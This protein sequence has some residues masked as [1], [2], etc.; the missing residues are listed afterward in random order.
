M[1]VYSD[2]PNLAYNFL[3]RN[4]DL[5]KDKT[6]L[7][8]NIK[9]LH[10]TLFSAET[11]YTF[12]LDDLEYWNFLFLVKDALKSHFDLLVE[13]NSQSLQL[14][15]GIVC[16]AETGSGFHGFRKREWSAQQGNLHISLYFKPKNNF[17]NIHAGVLIASAVSILETIDSIPGLAGLASTKWVNDI[18]INNSKVSGIITQTSSIGN[19]ISGAMIGI[20]LNVMTKPVFEKDRFTLKAACLKDF[21]DSPQCNIEFVLGKLLKNLT[22]NISMLNKKDYPQLFQKYCSRSAVIG[23]M[24]D[25]YSDPVSGKGE[26]IYS[27]KISGIN[28]NL[29]LMFENNPTPFRSGRLSLH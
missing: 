5:L 6:G 8:E 22:E 14:P 20:G 12:K 23:K 29:E 11:A 7:P 16:I 2:N 10:D 3:G 4:I 1:L 13:L 9:P 19:K 26:K 24:T 18:L 21:T 27:G 15:D 17:E 28:E 25:L